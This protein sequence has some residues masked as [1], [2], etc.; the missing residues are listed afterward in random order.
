MGFL[1]KKFFFS[2]LLVT[3]ICNNNNKKILSEFVIDYEQSSEKNKQASAEI[4][5]VTCA[6]SFYLTFH[7]QSGKRDC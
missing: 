6:C 3:Q 2:R 4:P 1:P 7:E 5:F